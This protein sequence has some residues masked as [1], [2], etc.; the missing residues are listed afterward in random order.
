MRLI[1]ADALTDEIRKYANDP[2]K[3]RDR[4]WDARCKAII[5]DMIGTVKTMPTIAAGTNE[6]EQWFE[7]WG[8]TPEAASQVLQNYSA[9]LCSMTGGKL[10]KI[11]YDLKTMETVANDYWN[12]LIDEGITEYKMSNGGNLK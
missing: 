4:R 12:M 6:K 9:F 10:S 11:G 8:L 1:D 3:L 7:D 5:A 2:V